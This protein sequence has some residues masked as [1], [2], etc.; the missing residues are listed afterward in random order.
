MDWEKSN[1]L[2]GAPKCCMIDNHSINSPSLEIRFFFITRKF[3]F[4]LF[5]H[6][7]FVDII[8]S[9]VTCRCWM[10]VFYYLSSEVLNDHSELACPR[11]IKLDIN[12]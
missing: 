12:F 1:S 5:D 3:P 2:V 7:R 6:F 11:N 4:K 9:F 10:M 8:K